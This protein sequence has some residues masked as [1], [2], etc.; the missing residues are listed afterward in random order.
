MIKVGKMGKQAPNSSSSRGAS[1]YSYKSS[2]A[3]NTTALT[4]ITSNIAANDN[5]TSTTSNH[6]HLNGG[7]IT[8][9]TNSTKLSPKS[10][11]Q[12]IRRGK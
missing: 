12:E 9:N 1:A 5:I 3:V 4:N 6:Q 11:A 10:M 8:T 2:S 7:D